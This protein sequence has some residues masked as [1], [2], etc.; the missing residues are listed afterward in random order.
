MLLTC[1]SVGSAAENQQSVDDLD[2]PSLEMLE[3]L[4]SFETDSGEWINPGELMQPEFEQ[5]LDSI[6]NSSG[7]ASEIVDQETDSQSNETE[8]GDEV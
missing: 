5:L 7:H 8:D 1:P 2:L 3:F 6:E 4:G